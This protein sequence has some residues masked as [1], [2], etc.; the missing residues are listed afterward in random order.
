LKNQYLKNLA[1]LNLAMLLISTSGVLG[2]YISIP[3]PATIWLRCLLAVIIIGGYCYF[4]KISFKLSKPTDL[5]SI[6]LAGL[7]LGAHWISY[8]Y[9][10]QL[11]NVAIAML[12]LFTFPVMTTFLEP[13]F[14]KSKLSTIHIFLGLIV[15]VGIYLLT[16][17]M[18]W[19]NSYT[20]G[21]VLGLISAL[22]YALRNLIIKQKVKSYHGSTL[23]F[24]QLV[25]LS[26]VLIPVLFIFEIR[27]TY[28]EVQAILILAVLTTAIGHTLFV[29]SLKNFSVSSASIM[30]GIQ[31]IY[32]IILAFLLLKEIPEPNT[33]LGGLLIVATVV[34]ESRHA[35]ER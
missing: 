21:I 15:L 35:R 18:D 14:F 13:L 17:E 33:L 2:R 22:C 3:P 12:S 9:S 7:F 29:N 28:E 26:I 10:L 20:K 4:K 30:S 16:P 32:G 5:K 31:P 1:E 24:Y 23:M 6:V 11:S 27:P 19:A 25:C 8:F 34:I